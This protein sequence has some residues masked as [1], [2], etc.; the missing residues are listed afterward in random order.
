L[1]NSSIKLASKTSIDLI[2]LGNN[3]TGVFILNKNPPSDKGEIF[4]GG[5]QK[6][7]DL[8]L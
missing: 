8:V 4:G 2:Y 6:P 7:Y 5:G 3:M 1:F